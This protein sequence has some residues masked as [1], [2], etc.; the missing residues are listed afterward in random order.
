M[1]ARSITHDE[2]LRLV[3]YEPET[4]KFYRIARRFNGG[5]L[6]P[7]E[8]KETGSARNR[9]GYIQMS[10]ANEVCVAHR[11]AWFYVHG[12]WPDVIDHI[13]GNQADN[14]LVNLRNGTQ[15]QNT[16][17]IR[18][19]KSHNSTGFLGVSYEKARGKYVA[20]VGF[21]GKRKVVGRFNTPEAAHEAYLK[22]KRELHAHATI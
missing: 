12:E 19:P 10:I 7:C 13:N 2:L 11:L 14:R 6:V 1:A 18:K 17:N 20:A 22:R 16:Q 15:A 4:G 21:G 9:D 5:R 3:R 8:P